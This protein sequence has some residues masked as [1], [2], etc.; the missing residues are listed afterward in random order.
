MVLLWLFVYALGP[1][2]VAANL[3]TAD[4]GMFTVGLVAVLVAVTC[5]SEAQR[6]LLVG[7]GI[8]LRP[9]RAFVTYCSGMFA[10]Q[11][12]PMGHAGG[13]VIMAYTI[14]SESHREYQHVLAAVSVEEVLN[15]VAS[16][17]LALIGL[18]Y[19]AAFAP[20]R[21]PRGRPRWAYCW[22]RSCWAGWW[23][24]CG[25]AAGQSSGRSPRSRS[26]CARPSDESP[27]KYV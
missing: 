5:W 25:T 16:F 18:A 26:C 27:R 23:R 24:R 22:G 6:H 11:V 2:T 8:H 3:R 1:S 9:H 7:S 12:L 17:G 21:Q 10:K 19:I 14:G 13:P 20:E 4:V 15:L